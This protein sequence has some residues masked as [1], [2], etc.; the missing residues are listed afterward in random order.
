MVYVGRWIESESKQVDI[1]KDS[2]SIFV[3][4]SSFLSS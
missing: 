3:L 4:L 2:A 1:Y